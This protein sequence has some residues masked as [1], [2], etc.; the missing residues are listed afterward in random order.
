MA[1]KKSIS[2]RKACNHILSTVTTLEIGL[3]ILAVSNL[4]KLPRRTHELEHAVGTSIVP[5]CLDIYEGVREVTDSDGTNADKAEGIVSIAAGAAH[6]A[7]RGYVFSKGRASKKAIATMYA[8]DMISNTVM[9]V[10]TLKEIKN[11]IKEENF[12]E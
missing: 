2:L 12:E 4:K 8:T 9:L 6:I 10:R 7:V 5:A 1:N 3:D 11:E